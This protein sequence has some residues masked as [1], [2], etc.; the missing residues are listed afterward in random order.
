[1]YHRIM[2]PVDLAHLGAL[3]RTL[4]VSADMAKHFGAEVCYVSVTPGTPGRVA[5]SPAEY[6]QKLKAFAE[7]QGKRHG[8][9]VSTKVYVSADPVADLDDLLVKA[10]DEV[11]V[12]L[13]IMGTHLPRKLDVIMPSHGG[14]V[15]RQTDVSVFL[16][17]PPRG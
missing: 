5:R 10:V 4:Q 7:E 1:M 6:E 11:G 13:V 8:R 15:A 16:V 3:E 17:R 14:K 2:V 9:P 12:D